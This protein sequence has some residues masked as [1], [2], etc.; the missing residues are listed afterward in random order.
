MQA[1]NTFRKRI[2]RGLRCD[3]KRTSE[4]DLAG[5]WE[6]DTS[7]PFSKAFGAI[8]YFSILGSPG[9]EH[10]FSIG[11]EDPPGQA[12]TGFVDSDFLDSLYIDERFETYVVYFTGNNPASPPIQ[13]PLGSW[14]GTGEAW[15]Y[16]IGMAILLGIK[17]DFQTRWRLLWWDKFFRPL[18]RTRVRW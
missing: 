7:D 12:L 8:Q 18:C 9:L 10:S 16:S 5:G 14:R 2:D 11:V 13:R 3:T 4:S 15:L 1:V 17:F 6:L